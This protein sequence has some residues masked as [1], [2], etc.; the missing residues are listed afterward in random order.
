MDIKA[1]NY[2]VSYDDA[3]TITCV[4]NFRLQGSDYAPITDLLSKVADATPAQITLDVRALSFLNSS[5]INALS[6]FVIRVR[7]LATSAMLV[8][9]S[10]AHVWQAKSLKNLARLKKDLVLEMEEAT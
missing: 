10:K 2:S 1:D 3:G 9:G 6:K 8:R 5:G 7:K 4:G